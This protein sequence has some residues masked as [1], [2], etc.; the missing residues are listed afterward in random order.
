MIGSIVL[1]HLS[2]VRLALSHGSLR[3]WFLLL[4]DCSDSSTDELISYG[5]HGEDNRMLFFE[6]FLDHDVGIVTVVPLYD[7][8]G[9]IIP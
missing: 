4:L 8:Y 7:R 3:I 1:D 5:G 9:S 6:L 2:V